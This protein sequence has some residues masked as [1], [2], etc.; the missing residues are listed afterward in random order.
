VSGDILDVLSPVGVS[1]EEC[2]SNVPG[3]FLEVIRHAV[4][5]GAALA[6]AAAFLQSSKDLCDM[7]SG[8]PP[9]EKPDDIGA[10]AVE[11]RV[12]AGAIAKFESIEDIICSAR[13]M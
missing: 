3:Q 7:A 4:R 12:A 6:L 11:F 2:L 8:C 13:D 5:R 9:M 1:V 10:L